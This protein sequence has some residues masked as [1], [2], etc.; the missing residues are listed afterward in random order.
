MGLG[1]LYDWSMA[2]TTY[3]KQAVSCDECSFTTTDVALFN[4]HSCDI[5]A[6]GGVCED[7]NED[8]EPE[9]EDHTS[10]DCPYGGCRDC[11]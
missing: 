9:V 11:D 1:R 3:L 4:N 7:F 10:N 6:N 2:N 8:D 5:Q